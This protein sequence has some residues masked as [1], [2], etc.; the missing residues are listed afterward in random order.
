MT[1]LLFYSDP[2][3]LQWETCSGRIKFAPCQI[4]ELERLFQKKMHPSRSEKEML[5]K[6]FGVPKRKIEV[7]D[8]VFCSMTDRE[9]HLLKALANDFNI[10]FNILS[11]LLNGN[12]ESVCHPLSTLLKRV[13]RMLNRC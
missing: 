10:C 5:S 3:P 13:E 8:F 4:A 7:F 2:V 11:I 12:V 6:L 1:H 9:V